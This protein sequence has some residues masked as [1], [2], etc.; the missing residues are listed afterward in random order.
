MFVRLD[1]TGKHELKSFA[2]G[3]P[4][5]FGGHF[6]VLPSGHVLV[7]IYGNSRV[8]EYDQEGKSVWEI[9][10]NMPTCVHRLPSGN[11]LVG[12]ML[13]QQVV[14][15]NKTGQQVWDYHCEGR[16]YRVRRR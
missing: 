5:L 4:Q 11:T 12:S 3:Q 1:P 16:L 14:E 7:P 2:V 10:A 9:S 8:L 13:N 6:E 15:L